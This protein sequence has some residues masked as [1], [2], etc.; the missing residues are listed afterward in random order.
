MDVAYR[1]LSATDVDD[2]SGNDDVQ[3]VNGPGGEIRYIVFNFDTQPYG[4][5]TAEADAEKA[6]A[7]RQAVADLVDREAISEQ[8]YK[9]TYTPLYSYVP[10]GFAGA[11][12]ALKGLYG[13][14]DGGPD[15]DKAAADT[16][17]RRRRDAGR[18]EPAVQPRP[19]RRRHRA[20]S[21]RWSR[22]SSRRA[23]CS[24]STSSRPSGCSTPRTARLTCTR[25]TSSAGSRTTPTP[26]TT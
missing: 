18:A 3:V 20:T 15:A 4:A 25:P 17:G 11:T 9:G 14:G 12:E 1:S 23:A 24:P 8:V 21:T 5:K 2:L 19:L 13:D 7:V 16:R 10:E 6:L 26:T 22:T